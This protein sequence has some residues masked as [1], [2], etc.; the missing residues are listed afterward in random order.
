MYAVISG[1]GIVD[2]VLVKLPT[3]EQAIKAA[4]Q[5]IKSTV[6][7]EGRDSG[8]ALLKSLRVVTLH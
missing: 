6:Q 1:N 2:T 5:T 7:R 4:L 3:V 8:K